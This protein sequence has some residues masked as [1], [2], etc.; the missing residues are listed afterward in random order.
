MTLTF[1]LIDEP[2]IPCV[3]TDGNPV[4]LGLRAVLVEAHTLRELSGES[5]LVTAALYRLL[6]AL[7]HRIFGPDGYDAWYDLWESGHFDHGWVSAY[8]E[9]WAHRFDLFNPEHPFYQAA[10][11]RVKPKS[12]NSLIL[13]LAFGNKATLFDH[14]TD[15][16][17]VLLTPA[18]GARA[19]V[20][21]QVFGLAGLSGLPQKF[22]DGTCAR[23][24]IFLV[25]GETLF[26]T[27]MLNLLRYP[28]DDDVMPHYPGDCPAWEM[29]DPFTPERSRPRGYLD[30]LTWQN[31]RILLMPEEAP[32]GIVIRHMT[33]A[34][35]LRLES[36]VSDPMKHYRVDEKR[37]L[38]VQRF[39]EE[40]ALWRDSSALFKL[41]DKSYRPPRT[42]Q[43]LSEL[44][45]EGGS[46]LGKSQTRRYIALGMA[47]NQAKV[48]FYRSEH[49]P[50]PLRY[51]TQ[52][53]LVQRL[54]EA[55]KMAEGVR[56]QLWGAA[57]TLATLLLSPQS[58]ADA[59]R[60]PA[61][62]DLDSLAG[63]WAI[64]RDYWSRLEIPFRQML[65][66]LPDDIEGTLTGWRETLHCTAWA[67]FD[68]VA[69]DLE[70]DP[71]HLKA[72]VRARDQLAAGLG[73]ALPEHKD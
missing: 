5:P 50:L 51:L 29:H 21:A 14:T 65:E 33:L 38:L 57:R 12:V 36:D 68:R 53:S 55:L 11:D 4:D 15:A 3:G 62:Q 20:A 24:V 18:E 60:Q 28:T 31:R 41:W 52:E 40:R 58:D 2:W 34:P 6:L 8:L 49:C 26:E 54:D 10:D 64:E 1:N 66:A 70:Y 9:Q 59:G 16:E 69:G 67:A 30:Y 61:R 72:T 23:G 63:Q 13:E 17:G 35:G 32:T 56:G 45:Y 73:K 46:D 42:F 39:N 43:W 27:L 19:V 7:L 71:R 37:G 47:N 25:Q 44:V 48:D 22:T